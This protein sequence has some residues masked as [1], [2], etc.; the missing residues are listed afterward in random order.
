MKNRQS[1]V[2]SRQSP[3]RFHCGLVTLMLVAWQSSYAHP[4]HGLTDHGVA[5]V[6]SSPFHVAGLLAI[7]LG[8]WGATWFVRHTI[9]RCVLRFG[10]V[11]AVAAA[12]FLWSSM[13]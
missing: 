3:T 7:A 5:H 1:S 4:G 13:A 6:V 9:G 8:C 12:A 11:V 10:A 2:V